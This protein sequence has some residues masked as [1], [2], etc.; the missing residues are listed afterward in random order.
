MNSEDL[1]SIGIKAFG[2][3]HRLLKKIKELTHSSSDGNI[4]FLIIRVFTACSDV[5]PPQPPQGTQLIE[6]STDNKDFI[7]TA[8]LVGVVYVKWVWS[9]H[10]I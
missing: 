5:V 9:W 1:Q 6:L 8:D 3:R 2:I 4:E 10:D 7:D